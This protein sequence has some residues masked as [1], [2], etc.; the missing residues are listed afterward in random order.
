MSRT[1][2]ITGTRSGIGAAT[3]DVLERLGHRVIGVDLRDADINSDLATSA[4]RAAMI[5]QATDMS[6][7]VLDG[8]FAVAGI[9]D[10]SPLTAQVNYFGAVAT[11][12][13]LRPLLTRSRAPRAVAV[14]SIALT[15]PINDLLL[16]ALVNGD[17]PAAV[18]A[19]QRSLPGNNLVYSTSK[20][21]L[22]QWVRKNAPMKDW[23]GAGIALNVVCPGTILT[24]LA[25]SFL[26]TREER[27]RVARELPA[28]LNGFAEPVVCAN[29]LAW[30]GGE[31][32]S[33]V[34]GQVIFLDG[35]TEVYLRPDRV[36]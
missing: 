8:V 33:H 23:A 19:A 34:T 7:G 26:L 13:G 2:L 18:C 30:L 11:L 1:Y 22:A 14:S 35:G 20:R 21:A 10:D 6:G 32:N 12:D 4:G 31:E 15:F 24:P 17:E 28:P 9:A 29:L 27:Q 16:A 5:D 25:K 36:L 3:K